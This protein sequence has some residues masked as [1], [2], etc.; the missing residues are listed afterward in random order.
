M[1]KAIRLRERGQGRCN[2][3]DQTFMGHR[4]IRAWHLFFRC[5][6]SIVTGPSTLRSVA[7]IAATMRSATDRVE[8]D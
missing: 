2:L 1:G 8:G 7:V 4:V 5:D 6:R 3:T